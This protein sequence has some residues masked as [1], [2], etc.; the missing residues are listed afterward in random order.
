MKVTARPHGADWG[1][2]WGARGRNARSKKRRCCWRAKKKSFGPSH[3]RGAR[4]VASES[5]AGMVQQGVG[6]RLRVSTGEATPARGRARGRQREKKGGVRAFFASLQAAL[7]TTHTAPARPSPFADLKHR[8]AIFLREWSGACVRACMCAPSL[9]LRAMK[10][11]L[12]HGW[13]RARGPLSFTHTSLPFPP[14]RA[15]PP[16]TP[17]AAAAASPPRAPRLGQPKP[18]QVRRHH[19]PPPRSQLW[20]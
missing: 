16:A 6:M 11:R 20:G 15:L 19:I 1:L 4:A 17:T 9:T 12:R 7:R 13:P 3:A 5:P 8:T 10:I 2:R 14:A 18:V